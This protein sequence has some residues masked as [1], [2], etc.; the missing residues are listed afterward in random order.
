M[1]AFPAYLTSFAVAC[2][3]ILLLAP[4][5]RRIGLVDSPRAHKAHLG[6]VP[7]VGGIAIFCGF[8]FGVLALDVPLNDLRPLFAGSALLVIVGVLDDFK[9]LDPRSR[10]VPQIAAGLMMTLWGGVRLTDL[11]AL[12]GPDETLLGAWSL[13]FT[14]LSVVGVTNALNMLDGIDGLAG[15][16]TLITLTILG[17]V[18]LSA[19]E[20]TS[21]GVLLALASSVLAFLCFNLRLPGRNRARVFMGDA[22]SM[23]LGFAVAWFLV[24]LSQGD[25]P[26]IEP[27]T[28]LWV[29]AIPL[30]DTV[31]TML[32]RLLRQRSPFL[33][34]REHLHHL[35]QRMGLSVGGTVAAILAASAL[36]AGIGLLAEANDIS[37]RNLFVAFLTLFAV[38]FCTTEIAWR[39]LR[40]EQLLVALRT[41]GV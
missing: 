27:V 2:G 37:E 17:L 41:P 14:L 33:A 35:L 7:L 9:E 39:R 5:A 12:S 22:G 15:G 38:Y 1:Q 20:A 3:L 40:R 10:F 21:A 34:D 23:F 26:A 19:G 16:L 30:M 24:R 36:M 31:G 13:P 8:L 4:L 25:E 29:V 28:A 6:D 11:G 18:A 32:R